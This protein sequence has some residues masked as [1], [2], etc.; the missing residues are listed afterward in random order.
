MAG[1]NEYHF[2][3]R[4]QVA[5][6]C[7]E[8]AD[9]LGDPVS[10]RWWPAVYLRVDELELPDSRGLGRRARLLTKGW[11]PYTLVGIRRH[12]VRLS[13]RVCD[14]R[15]RRFHRAVSGRSSR[16]VRPST[17]PTI[18]GLPRET[19]VSAFVVSPAA[20]VRGEPPL[21]D[22]AGGDEPEVEPRAGVIPDALR[23]GIAPPPGPVTYA[24]AGCWWSCR[25]AL[26]SST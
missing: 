21:G 20:V 7:G 24:A 6:T 12:R 22:D 1:A 10:P 14:R 5:G 13:K 2:I 25:R 18:G 17:S 11:L 4:W 8:V 23:A 3:T 15:H 19:A 9:V 16:M 26:A